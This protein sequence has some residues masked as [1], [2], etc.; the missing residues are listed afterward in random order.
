[1]HHA[2]FMIIC[3]KQLPKMCSQTHRYKFFKSSECQVRQFKLNSFLQPVL[4]PHL[5]WQH[6]IMGPPVI[7]P[8][9]MSRKILKMFDISFLFMI[10]LIS[11]CPYANTL[12]SHPCIHLLNHCFG[13]NSPTS[14]NFE[15]TLHSQKYH[16]DERLNEREWN[17]TESVTNR[18]K[19]KFGHHTLHWQ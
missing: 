2:S 3:S 8:R 14:T 19:H 6:L 5:H 10:G 12:T 18:K 1:M 13:I 16:D 7:I 9:C 15:I 17:R 11:L 4:L